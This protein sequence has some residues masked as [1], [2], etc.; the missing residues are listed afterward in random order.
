[1]K[2]KTYILLRSAGEQVF[3]SS[4]FHF[5]CMP[6]MRIFW[7]GC[8]LFRRCKRQEEEMLKIISDYYYVLA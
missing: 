8:K 3:S 7:I 6:N 4:T 5:T 1:M 2:L